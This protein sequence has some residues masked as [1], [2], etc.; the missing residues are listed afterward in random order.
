MKPSKIGVANFIDKLAQFKSKGD[1]LS[2]IEHSLKVLEN[3]V[4]G[5]Y[6]CIIMQNMQNNSY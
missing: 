1:K 5:I 3:S 4:T 6:F 2:K